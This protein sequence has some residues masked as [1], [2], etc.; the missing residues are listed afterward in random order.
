MACTLKGHIC[1]CSLPLRKR[2]LFLRLLKHE[3]NMISH[4]HSGGHQKLEAWKVGWVTSKEEN[5]LVRKGLGLVEDCLRWGSSAWTF[6][7]HLASKEQ[8]PQDLPHLN[9]LARVTLD[10]Q[11]PNRQTVELPRSLL[12][13]QPCSRVC[14]WNSS[15]GKFKQ[16][17]KNLN[18]VELLYLLLFFFFLKR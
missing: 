12:G 4:C 8:S 15:L 7:I 3:T 10:R 9:V 14:F 11:T 2:E 13:Q 6:Q 17:K 5:F 1:L 18:C 16:E